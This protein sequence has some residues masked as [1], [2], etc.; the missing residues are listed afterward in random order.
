[1][2]VAALALALA[3]GVACRDAPADDAVA[4]P[5]GYRL[6]DYDAPVPDTLSGARTVTAVDVRALLAKGAVIVDVIP[7]H[8]PP[9]RLP[10]GQL[11]MP[12][13]H[14]GVP[15]ALWLPDTGFGALAPVTERYFLDHLE[16]ASGGE[17]SRALVFYCRMDCWMS[18]NAARR[19]LLAGYENVHWFRDG[20]DDWRFEGYPVEPLEPAPGSRLPPSA[21]EPGRTER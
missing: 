9:P 21:P 18:W 11:W 14:S 1:M 16:R 17:R 15:G 12:P 3:V 6:Q 19:A 20:I 4:E 5:E 13:P 2:S 8:R 10:D 7:A